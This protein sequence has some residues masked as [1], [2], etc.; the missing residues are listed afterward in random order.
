MGQFKAALSENIRSVL[1]EY[2]YVDK[3][4]RS[5]FYAFYAKRHRSYDQFCFRLHLFDHFPD[6]EKLGESREGYLGSMVLRPTDIT[7]LGRTLL[8]PKAIKDFSGFVCEAEFENNILGLPFSLRTFPHTMQDS[9][10]TICAHAVCWMIA[11]YYSEKYTVL[12][13]NDPG[14]AQGTVGTANA[15]I[16]MA[17]RIINPWM[18]Q[19][20][21]CGLQVY[22]WLNRKPIWIKAFL[23]IHDKEKM[24]INDRALTEKT[25]HYI[26]DTVLL[27]YELY[28]SNLRWRTSWNMK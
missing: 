28:T 2:P 26:F 13:Q 4:Y 5:T 11:R 16:H 27:P 18:L 23:F 24:V 3:D 20:R 9:D 7:P 15:Q 19:S 17:C 8:S 21:T 1:I 12:S 6:M 22:Y 10:V 25:Y 14:Y